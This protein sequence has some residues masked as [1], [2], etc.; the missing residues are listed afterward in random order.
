MFDKKIIKALQNNLIEFRILLREDELLE[1][2]LK[3]GIE[4]EY[5]ILRIADD[6]PNPIDL[7]L[8]TDGNIKVYEHHG[9]LILNIDQVYNDLNSLINFL[10]EY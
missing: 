10:K 9:E 2:K 4:G 6:S 5:Q 8:T 3:V 1:E 7:Y